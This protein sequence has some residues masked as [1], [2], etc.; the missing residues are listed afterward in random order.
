[1]N[2]PL[3]IHCCQDT[4]Y[5]GKDPASSSEAKVRGWALIELCSIEKHGSLQGSH[6]CDVHVPYEVR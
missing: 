3:H 6:G 1:M 4:G 2:G 5:T